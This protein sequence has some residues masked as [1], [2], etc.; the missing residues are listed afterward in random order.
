MLFDCAG[1][2]IINEL[3]YQASEFHGFVIVGVG[4]IIAEFE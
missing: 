1:S 3:G 2:Q 4:R